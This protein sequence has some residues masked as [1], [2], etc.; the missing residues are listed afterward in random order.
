MTAAA[1]PE[2]AWLIGCG[3]MAGAMVE[4]WRAA[5]LD[6]SGATVIRPSGT[7]V[8]SVRTVTD[9]P[10]EQPR[11]A[12]LGIKPQ[13]LDEVAPGLAPHI[14]A[15]TIVV[16][17]LAGVTAA[18]LR[19]RF[20]AARAIVRIMPNLPVA[21]RAGVTPLFS[22]DGDAEA[23]GIVAG[24]MELLGLAPWCLDEGQISAIGA[25]SASGPAYFARFAEAIGRAAAG[26]GL[27]P[28]LAQAIAAQTL[29]G[30][31][32]FAADTGESMADIARRVASPKGTT[33]QGL[34][35]LDAPD[36]LHPLVDR[37]IGAALRRVD[38]LAAEAAGR[39]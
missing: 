6:F 20:P 5:E 21:Q 29:I 15:E 19:E 38:E 11:F 2:P 33:E 3:N 31:G 28:A 10:D 1:F 24:L 4:G 34:A 35:V 37:M 13:K 9:Y 8:T 12:M 17:M 30:T 14:G 22:Q 39:D 18:G 25:V 16:S 26:R 23:R 27:D 7:P 36:G 32:A